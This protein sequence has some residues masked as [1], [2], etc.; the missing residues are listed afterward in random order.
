MCEQHGTEQFYIHVLY[1]YLFKIPIIIMYSP[2]IE[3]VVFIIT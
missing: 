1:K 2:G 3:F